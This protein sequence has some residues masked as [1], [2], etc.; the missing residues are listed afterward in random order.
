MSRRGLREIEWG[1]HEWDHKLCIYGLGTIEPTRFL[2]MVRNLAGSGAPQDVRDALTPDE[3]RHMRFRPLSPSEARERGLDWGVL[4][5]EEG[6]YQ[7]TS[8]IV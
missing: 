7:V 4:E 1:I 5:T 3:V 6:G 2:D 8:V